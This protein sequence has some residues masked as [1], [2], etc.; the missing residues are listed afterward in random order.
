[1][2]KYALK[3]AE[4]HG[5]EGWFRNSEDFD[6]QAKR[7][8]LECPE[9][10]SAKVEKALMA[11]AIAKSG[12]KSGSGRLADIREDMREAAKK[13]RDYVEK[14]FD[15]VGEKFPEEARRI[16][17]GES[18][19]RNIYGEATLSEAKELVDEGVTIA[20]LPGNGGG[21]TTDNKKLN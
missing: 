19:E 13:A 20:P 4:G 12:A 5:F 16:H 3:C 10:G 6:R 15:N 17:Y 18:P 8:L 1:M 21:K 2:I 14:N 11:P 9:C 7:K